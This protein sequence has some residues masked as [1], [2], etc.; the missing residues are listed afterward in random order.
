MGMMTEII[1]AR[2]V[3][4]VFTQAEKTVYTLK[5]ECIENSLYGVDIDS[6]AV[7]IAKLRLWLSLVVDED[8]I[9]NIKPLPNLDYKIMCGDSLLGF[10]EGII[11]DPEINSRLED[12]KKEYFNISN[13]NR[14]LEKRIEINYLFTQLV[15]SAKQ[16]D[17]TLSRI[18][19]DFHTHFSEVFQEKG[20]FDILIANPPYD[21][22]QGVRQKE[23]QIIRKFP[24]YL[25]ATG[26]KLN[27]YK[28]FLAKSI[29]LQKKNGI[30]CEIFQNSFLGDKSA[31]KLR[32]N[33]LKNQEILQI[34]SFPE[35]D[36]R[37]TRVFEDV[38]MSVCILLSKNCHKDNYYF[39][40]N[41]WDDKYMS[42]SKE[43]VLSN[44]EILKLDPKN[45]SIPLIDQNEINI[46]KKISIYKKL[47]LF[48]SCYEGEIN[49][50]F[51]KDYLHNTKSNNAAM[52]KGAAVQKWFIKDKMS[53]GE[54][55]YLDDTK[56]LKTYSGEKTN[57]HKL[58]RIVMQG[59][60]GVDEKDR[61][62][63]TIIDPDIYCGNS[64]NYILI[65]N[66]NLEYEY[67][68]ALLNSKLMNWYFKIF[69][70]NSN[71]NGYEVN[72]FPIRLVDNQIQKVFIDLVDH[73]LS[74]K[75][76][77]SDSDTYSI[78][79]E[80]DRLVYK[81]YGLTQKEIAIVEGRD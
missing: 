55:E 59:I 42:S 7:E 27:T 75:K 4:A 8:D 54:I 44:N 62:K 21:V 9:R 45:Y 58:K 69:S 28:L 41:I 31:A 49:L 77:D 57:H 20:G 34:D 60:T 48:A 35:R 19:F 30:L 38:K 79:S 73:I 25:I 70:T 40:L 64:V 51:H 71:V 2:Q 17:P 15:N 50:T 3:L 76:I 13:P 33:F 61:L 72:N 43:I 23:I 22:Y 46:L 24:C 26:G 66:N 29:R 16:Y 6:G 56:F 39:H 81:L 12:C 63:M 78:E 52:I 5:R 11:L 65:H 68:L 14:K 80:I 74:I 47:D 67:L 37:K 1:K 10:P 53:Q 32:Y 18:N 36:N